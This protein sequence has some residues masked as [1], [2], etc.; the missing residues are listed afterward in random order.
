LLEE[1][2][3]EYVVPIFSGLRYLRLVWYVSTIDENI[4]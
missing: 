2:G 1:G 3:Y 4:D